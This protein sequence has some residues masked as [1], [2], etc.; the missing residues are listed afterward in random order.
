MWTILLF[1]VPVIYGE[2][3]PDFCP[4][5]VVD[6]DVNATVDDLLLFDISLSKQC[7]D[8][9]I[10]HSAV[11]AM[12]D[13]AF[14]FGN[15]ETQI[16]TDFGKYLAF[17][18]YQVFSTLNHFLFKNFKKTK[19]L[20][21]RY[22]KLCLDV[23]SYIHIQIICSPF[24][25]FIRLRRMNETGISPRIL[26][27]TFYLQNKRNNTWVAIK[28]YLG[29]DDPF[30]YRIWHT[31]THAK[32]FLI[33]SCEND[34]NQLFF[35]QR[36]YLSLAKT[37]EATF[38]Q[39]FNPMIE[40][41]N[42]QR[43]RTNNID[44]SFSKFRQNGVKVAVCKYT[45]WGVSGFGSLEV[46][47]KIKSPF[48][49]E[50]KRVGFNSTGAFTPLYGS[51]VLW[52]LIFLRVEMTTYVCTCTNKNTGTQIQV[53]LPD[54]DLDLLDSEKTSSNVFVDM[55]C[56]TLIAILFL[57]FVTAVVLLG[58]SC[59]DGVQKVLTWPLQHIQK[60]PVSEKIINLTNLMFGQEPLP[61]KESLKQQCL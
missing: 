6:F 30:T 52:G 31:L 36:K 5:A 15:S 32:N 16:E 7:S 40:Q 58:V 46:L 11:A 48:G 1:C 42:E 18:C 20:M 49:E 41:R 43:Y 12:T 38:K 14:F 59:L 51:D 50:W 25:S 60:E 27:T 61:K 57:A 44:C 8:D 29:E 10:R 4:L 54:V 13:N 21:K 17:N 53:T 47:Q 19:G 33:N 24:K 26:E 37:F 23:E 3:Y 2:L 56:Y 28:N 39:G 22:D 9:K 35:W 45:G 55:L 34:F